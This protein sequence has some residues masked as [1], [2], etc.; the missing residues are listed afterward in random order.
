[1]ICLK[2]PIYSSLNGNFNIGIINYWGQSIDYIYI[3][4]C[5]QHTVSAPPAF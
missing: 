2:L 5:V 3:C 1:M 4:V